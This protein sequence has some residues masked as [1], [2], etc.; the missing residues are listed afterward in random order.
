MKYSH[1]LALIF[2]LV[3]GCGKVQ[4]APD[5]IVVARDDSPTQKE[6]DHRQDV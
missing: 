2:F 6:T 4:S 5:K 3:T 1:L